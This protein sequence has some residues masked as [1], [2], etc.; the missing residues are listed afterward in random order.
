MEATQTFHETGNYVPDVTPE[1]SICEPELE[2]ENENVD[3]EAST[4]NPEEST[5]QSSSPS[6][7]ASGCASAQRPSAEHSPL[8]MFVFCLLCLI[9]LRVGQ[10]NTDTLKPIWRKARSRDYENG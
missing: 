8:A 1:E 6:T 5:S 10:R 7:T 3:A 9:A 4:E 2:V